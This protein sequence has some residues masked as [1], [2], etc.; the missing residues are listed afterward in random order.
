MS[1]PSIL[2][3]D[4]ADPLWYKDAVIYQLHVKTFADSNGDGIGDFK[5]LTGKL[6]YLKDLGV[7][8]LWLLPMY[9][10]PSGTMATTSRTT[11]ASTRA[12]ARSRSFASSSMRPTRGDCG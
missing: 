10:S 9:P 3:P 7:D 8:C 11:A 2:H 1:G 4:V 12:T 5:G 6:D